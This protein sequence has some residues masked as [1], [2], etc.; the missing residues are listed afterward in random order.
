VYWQAQQKVVLTERLAGSVGGEGGRRGGFESR[1]HLLKFTQ[2]ISTISEI[3]MPSTTPVTFR[4]KITLEILICDNIN[5]RRHFEGATWLSVH[6]PNETRNF[7]MR[8]DA[9]ERVA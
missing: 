9:L 4:N 5:V 3:I 6:R 1:K 7:L 2:E 8:E